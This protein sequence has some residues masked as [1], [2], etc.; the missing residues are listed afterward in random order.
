MIERYLNSIITMCF[1]LIILAIAVAAG[2][3]LQALSVL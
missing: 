1:I 2:L 3:A